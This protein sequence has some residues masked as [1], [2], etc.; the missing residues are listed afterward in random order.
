M[1]KSILQFSVIAAIAASMTL[2]TSCSSDD[3]VETFVPTPVQF[4]VGL[5]G[6]TVAKTRTY[7]W[8]TGGTV[9]DNSSI[10]N[11]W[12]Y[13][14][15]PA[16]AADADKVMLFSVK[17]KDGVTATAIEGYEY[18]VSDASN[19]LTATDVANN[20]QFYWMKSGEKKKVIA[21]SYGTKTTL[22]KSDFD[23]DASSHDLSYTVD[24]DQSSTTWNKELLWGYGIVE[25]D[26]NKN[27][28]MYHQLA[29]IDIQITAK[30]AS[31]KASSVFIGRNSATT[32]S[33]TTG[34]EFLA[35]KGNFSP[36]LD[37]KNN[38]YNVTTNFTNTP[39]TPGA[40]PES[41]PSQFYGNWSAETAATKQFI[42]PHAV[43]YTDP[44][45][46]GTKGD[47]IS[48]YSAVVIPQTHAADKFILFE[49]T[50]DGVRYIY[51]PD[52]AVNWEP[53]KQYGYDI[54]ISPSGINVTATIQNWTHTSSEEFD[55][56]ASLD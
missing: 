20:A 8:K 37:H 32:T 2:T 22:N 54:T 23:L 28:P 1:K 33:I 19:G 41:A 34:E 7:D 35:L 12:V 4:T 21:W 14:T 9:W 43:A 3:S 47:H 11:T 49:I 25:A 16:D 48:Q 40:W 27:I 18:Y 56:N 26:G 13:K 51:I 24:N 50:V 45:S 15:T 42:T 29:R 36:V 44:V 38:I 30:D 52:T 46:A 53:G 17:D 10:G 31:N 55:G 5:N 39:F 6:R